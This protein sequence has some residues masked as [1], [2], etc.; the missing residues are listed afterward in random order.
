[1]LV[2]VSPMFM[3]KLRINQYQNY[4]RDYQINFAGY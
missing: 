2:N 3:E 1:M 4:A